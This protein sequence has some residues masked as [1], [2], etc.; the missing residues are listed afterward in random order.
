M[1]KIRIS[2]WVILSF[3]LAITFSQ[4]VPAST[5]SSQM[6]VVFVIDDSG[7]MQYSDPNHLSA[8]AVRQFLDILP[9]KG[10]QVGVVTYGLDAEESLSLREIRG[11]NDKE[12]LK[13][14]T[15]TNLQQNSLWTDSA[16]GLMKAA[17]FLDQYKNP[18]HSQTIVLITDGHNDY[19]TTGRTDEESNQMLQQV[20]DKGY[21]INTIG[22]T[23][24]DE[25]DVQYLANIAYQTGGEVY[26]PFTAEEL[27]SIF[28][29]I[30]ANSMNGNVTRK[31]LCIGCDGPAELTFMIP[32]GVFETNIQFTHTGTINS[33]LYDPSDA[34]VTDTAGISEGNSYTNIKLT[35]PEPGNWRMVVDGDVQENVEFNII[36]SYDISAAIDGVHN[37]QVNTDQVYQIV[38]FGKDGA[39]T[40]QDTYQAFTC[41]V[42]V[43]DP[44]GTQETIEAVNCGD[45][46][47][48]NLSYADVGNYELTANVAGRKLE[49]ES[50]V[51]PVEITEALAG[52]V[53]Q[54]SLGATTVKNV[55]NIVITLLL[56][57][58]LLF[59]IRLLF[60]RAKKMKS[61]R[62]LQ[63]QMK[64]II[65]EQDGTM[66]TMWKRL[67]PF[68]GKASLF[69]VI[70]RIP[71]LEG[72]RDIILSMNENTTGILVQ[73]P[74]KLKVIA[75]GSN[76][77][78][79]RI[80][81]PS[82]KGFS[83]ELDNR[84]VAVTYYRR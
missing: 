84:A 80:E 45:H 57:I 1:K 6:D 64:I 4:N 16:T 20:M 38:L 35:E 49:L 52:K 68:G 53:S 30:Q 31:R 15:D 50:E 2:V 54:T 78:A 69:D 28:V 81:I 66:S 33:T 34:D 59:T 12:E 22:L 5:S 67:S 39:L 83:V 13:A 36:Y 61:K 72:L 27:S 75:R 8:E 9:E 40:D 74:R 70:G 73:N 71:S 7:S 10:D 48:M 42:T 18:N 44:E 46:Y 21:Q 17:E 60:R 56:L 25:E 65:T 41:S 79:E 19:G 37:S 3:M 62:A 77:G 11:E 43:T 32:E 24:T 55:L 26:L 82:D 14:F 63:G 29:D 76:E 23:L 51:F 47:E 58:I